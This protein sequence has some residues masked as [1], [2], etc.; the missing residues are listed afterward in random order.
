MRLD[1]ERWKARVQAD[2]E[3]AVVLSP[4]RSLVVGYYRRIVLETFDCFA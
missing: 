2:G 1:Y 3:G 4:G